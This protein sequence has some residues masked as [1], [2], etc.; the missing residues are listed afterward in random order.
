MWQS[1]VCLSAGIVKTAKHLVGFFPP[2][3]SQSFWSCGRFE[4]GTGSHPQPGMTK[5][6][7]KKYSD[8]QLISRSYSETVRDGDIFITITDYCHTQSQMRKIVRAG[9][10]NHVVC[11]DFE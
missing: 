10:S 4:I 5:G 1:S 8:L 3:D 6:G 9:V 11:G 7:Y 2:P